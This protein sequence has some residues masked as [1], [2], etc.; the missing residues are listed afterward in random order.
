MYFHISSPDQTIYQGEVLQVTLPTP[1]GE[2]TILPT[3]IPL[4]SMVSPGIVKIKTEKTE[5]DTDRIYDD[6]QIQISIS[7]GIV[8]IDGDR[9]NVLTSVATANPQQTQEVLL[10]NKKNLEAKLQETHL[11]TSPE[12]YENIMVELMKI[13]ADLKLLKSKGMYS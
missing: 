10:A 3:H 11:E 7:K 12:E 9:I 6:N 13:Q 1:Q 5:S 4:I 8:Y 2:I